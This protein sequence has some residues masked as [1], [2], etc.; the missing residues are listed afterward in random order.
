MQFTAQTSVVCTAL[1]VSMAMLIYYAV[2]NNTDS[3]GFKVFLAIFSLGIGVF[4]PSPDY[5]EVT[6]S[7]L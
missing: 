1:L 7:A 5:K 3:D 6:N 2:T 4:V